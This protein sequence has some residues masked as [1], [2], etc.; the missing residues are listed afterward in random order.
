MGNNNPNMDSFSQL[1]KHNN[2]LTR[3]KSSEFVESNEDFL[4]EV[5]KRVESKESVDYVK[6]FEDSTRFEFI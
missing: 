6:F 2:L 4:R 3:R 5:S 1:N